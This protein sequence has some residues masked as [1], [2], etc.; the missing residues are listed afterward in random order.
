[1]SGQP[2]R[3]TAAGATVRQLGS[4]LAYQNAWMTVRE[5]DVERPDGSQGIYGVVDKPDFALI[6]PVDADGFHLVEQYRYPVGGRFW[7]FPQ[8]S[9][10]D[11]AAAPAAVGPA[12]PGPPAGAVDLARAELRE[13]T[14]LLAGS[15]TYLGRIHVAY[16]YSS[17][18]CH[19][20]VAGDL[21]PGEPDREAAEVDMVSRWVSAVELDQMVRDGRLTDAASLAALALWDRSGRPHRS[22]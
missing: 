13:E 2:N 19:I 12:D 5:D 1:V 3:G 7:E 18:G 14:G 17:Q 15:L 10:P 21:V 4:R 8:G 6:L 11:P 9:W 16:G 20:F 22:G